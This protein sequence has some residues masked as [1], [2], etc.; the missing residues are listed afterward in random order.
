MSIWH[1]DDV[2]TATVRIRSYADSTFGA[3]EGYWHVRPSQADA[4]LPRIRAELDE[5]RKCEPGRDWRL[6]FRGTDNDWHAERT[7]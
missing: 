6:E 2:T 4:M 1:L 7:A 3:V 5:L